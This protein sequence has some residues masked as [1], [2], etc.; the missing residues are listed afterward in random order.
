MEVPGGRGAEGR[1]VSGGA[2]HHRRPLAPPG[3]VCSHSGL[4]SPSSCSS[5]TSAGTGV[6][7]QVSRVR[8]G[9][10][11]SGLESTRSMRAKWMGGE[12]REK[13]ALRVR[14]GGGSEGEQLR[15]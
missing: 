9:C 7:A 3:S 1:G 2:A 4:R 13:G 8:S 5:R 15:T 12:R 10:W 11:G 6:A 14:E